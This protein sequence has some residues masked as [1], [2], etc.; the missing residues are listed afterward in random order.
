MSSDLGFYAG[1]N[2]GFLGV[3]LTLGPASWSA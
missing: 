3:A 1:A 2:L